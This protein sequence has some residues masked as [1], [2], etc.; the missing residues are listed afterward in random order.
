MFP[1]QSV[2]LESLLARRFFMYNQVLIYS[3]SFCQAA[4]QV[5]TEECIME[6]IIILLVGTSSAG[7]ST[8]AKRLQDALSDH[9]LLLGIDDIFRM[10]SERWGGGMGGP[11][12]VDGFRY[13]RT[14]E[15]G[16]I[17]IRYGSVGKQVLAGMH[18]AVAAF[19]E[20]GNNIIVDEMLLD[21]WCLHDWVK[22]LSRFRSYVVN[23]TATLDVLE[24]RERHRGN[25]PGLAKGHVAINTLRYYDLLLDTTN[26]AP[27]IG[28]DSLLR[29]LAT[30]PKASAI[31]SYH[32]NT[33]VQ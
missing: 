21:E 15:P 24:Q 11:L 29:W 26:F 2:W 10:V 30:C 9:F 31:E 20:A 5:Q 27:E 19:A 18:R 7:K 28:V 25:E 13:D 16:V 6:P 23:V 4:C 12:S 22:H 14:T 17:T 3:I 32:Q 8:L 1:L 33:S